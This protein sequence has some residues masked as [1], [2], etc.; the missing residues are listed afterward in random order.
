MAIGPRVPAQAWVSASKGDGLDELRTAVAQAWAKP[1]SRTLHLNF[2]RPRAIESGSAQGRARGAAARTTAA[3][4][5]DVELE[6]AEIDK[7]L[8][9]GVGS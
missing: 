6:L 9:T 7:L 1:D 5:I 4:S 8:G 2:G 3:G